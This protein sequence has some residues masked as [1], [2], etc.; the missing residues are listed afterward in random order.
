M[1]GW[2]FA[3]VDDSKDGAC[4]HRDI[5]LVQDLRLLSDELGVAVTI[6]SDG[7]VED[8]DLS[9]RLF[10]H[11]SHGM[12]DGESLQGACEVV[13]SLEKLLRLGA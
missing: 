3:E 12:R 5:L 7:D 4:P 2:D 1:F 9:G 11:T 6:F 10:R 13:T 8:L